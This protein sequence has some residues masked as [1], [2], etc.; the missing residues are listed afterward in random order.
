MSVSLIVSVRKKHSSFK[1]PTNKKNT[2]LDGF[3]RTDMMKE[4]DFQIEIFD[5]IH[6]S[7]IHVLKTETTLAKYAE[8]YSMI[9]KMD[10]FFEPI[11]PGLKR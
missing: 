8:A 5:F 2:Y 10:L 6:C 9:P 11:R 1:W 4:A 7:N 3:L